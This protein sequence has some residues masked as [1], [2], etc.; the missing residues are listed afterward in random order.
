MAISSIWCVVG[1]CAC[2]RQQG[3][4]SAI[5]ATNVHI[6]L[7][8]FPWK[9]HQIQASISKY[10]SHLQM[11]C[12]SAWR[13]QSLWSPQCGPFGLL[14]QTWELSVIF[15]AK[16]ILLIYFDCVLFFL[17]IL[18]SASK[19]QMASSSEVLTCDRHHPHRLRQKGHGVLRLQGF[20]LEWQ[21]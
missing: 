7:G 9:P 13:P 4:I 21:S 18:H 17:T 11:L 19:M 5:K 16:S 20:P 14:F 10:L 6:F 12:C 3:I 2:L 8:E 1:P 15:S